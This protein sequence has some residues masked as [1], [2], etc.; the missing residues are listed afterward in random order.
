[1]TDA[2]NI[3]QASHLTVAYKLSE[4]KS[5][6]LKEWVFNRLKGRGK[7]QDFLAVNDVSF[8]MK[9]GESVALVGHNGS[10]KSTLLRALAGIIPPTKDGYARVH[11]RI[12]P[13][14]ELGAGFDGEL[15][16]RENIYLSCLLMGLT[17]EEV[18]SRIEAIIDFSELREFI[19]VPVKNYSSGMYARLG[20]ACATSVDPDLLIVDE[21]LA[22]GDTNF[23]EKCHKRIDELRQNG[24]SVLIV[25]HDEGTVRRFCDRAVVM[26]RGVAVFDGDVGEA[27]RVQHEIMMERAAAS[28]TPE[29]RRRRDKHLEL[30][31]RSTKMSASQRP[32]PV[33]TSEVE[34]LSAGAQIRFVDLAKNFVVRVKVRLRNPEYI[35]GDTFFGMEIRHLTGARIGGLGSEPRVLMSESDLR[36]RS[37][38]EVSFDFPQG[39]NDLCGGRYSLIFAMNDMGMDRNIHFQDFGEFEFTNSSRGSN[40]H[41]DIISLSS[42][43]SHIN[44][45]GVDK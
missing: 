20:F 22:V 28:M 43:S 40:E 4:Y 10:G 19:H 5:S 1:M 34:F 18:E 16:G 9:R 23:A 44:V 35:F 11:G 25:S 26:N 37:H 33:I 45:T 39:I 12:A 13:L 7:S 31:E 27:Y 42:H 2:E 24:V 6:T 17:L 15:S 41:S 21:V 30:M 29:E 38:L 32:K 3:V 8:E 36:K 14:I